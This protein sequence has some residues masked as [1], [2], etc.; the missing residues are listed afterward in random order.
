MSLV[1]KQK[2]VKN[3]PL[4]FEQEVGHMEGTPDLLY[5]HD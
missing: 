3:E 2:D 5:S 1:E 4:H